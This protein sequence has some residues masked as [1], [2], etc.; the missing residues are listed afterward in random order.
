ME[1]VVGDLQ[2]ET[3]VTGVSGLTM[4]TNPHVCR[5]VCVVW[6]SVD[7]NIAGTEAAIVTTRPRPHWL[8]RPVQGTA[9]IE[10]L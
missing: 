1:T 7:M 3:V 2:Q 4:M 6:C 10:N 9:A 5:L 8:L